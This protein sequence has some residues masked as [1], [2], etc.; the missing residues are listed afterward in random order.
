MRRQFEKRAGAEVQK[1]SDRPRRSGVRGRTT[2]VCDEE[3]DR[4]ERSGID[5]CIKCST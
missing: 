1:L 4:W 5:S 2:I 3:S